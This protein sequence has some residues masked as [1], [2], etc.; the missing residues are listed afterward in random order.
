MNAQTISSLSSRNNIYGANIMVH[1]N[2]LTEKRITMNQQLY[3]LYWTP[4]AK[5]RAEYREN[6]CIIVMNTYLMDVLKSISQ[7]TDLI[8]TC[9]GYVTIRDFKTGL[10]AVIHIDHNLNKI[11][12]VTCGD[13]KELYPRC[14]DFVIQ[15]NNNGY[16]FTRRWLMQ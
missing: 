10:F 5:Y 11:R 4:H 9:S 12:V 1:S 3:I 6:S 13:V 2:L 7:E 8:Q 14:N 15:R 16:I